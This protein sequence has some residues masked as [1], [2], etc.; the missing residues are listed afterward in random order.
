MQWTR[1]P[2]AMASMLMGVAFIGVGTAAADSPSERDWFRGQAV[3][4]AG[5]AGGEA[6]AGGR[7]FDQPGAQVAPPMA[8]NNGRQNSTAQSDFPDDPVHDWVV[9]SAR[10]AR[11]RAVLHLVEKQLNDAI[12]DAQWTFEQSHEYRDASA[13]EKQA[14]DNYIAERQ[15]AL[16]SVVTDPKYQAAIRLRDDLSD[17]IARFRAASKA[18]TLPREELLA[19]AS[20]KLQYASDAHNMERDALDMNAVVQDARQK[21]VQASARTAELRAAFDT[22]IR[23]N[24]QIAQARRNLDMARVELITAEAY[25]AAA[26]E[27]SQVATDYSYYRHRWDGLASPVVSPG[28]GGGGYVAGY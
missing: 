6:N 3:R 7:D 14:Y 25:Y 9:A 27:A 19:L 20:Q 15:K 17:Q 24:P 11:S 2:V 26:A 28:W 23:M 10:S 5:D 16:Q 21:M 4:P 13:A 22:S 1:M 8:Q 18:G 12:R